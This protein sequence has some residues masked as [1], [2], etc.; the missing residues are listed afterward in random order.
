[1][2]NDV[3]FDPE[4][5]TYRTRHDSQTQ[6]SVSTTVALAL[7]EI[8]DGGVESGVLYDAVDPDALDSLF[9]PRTAGRSFEHGRVSFPIANHRVI[10]HANGTI[11]IE[12]LD[13]ANP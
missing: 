10:V 11:E 9:R 3:E 12:P 7:E 8:C 4:T 1:M 2:K 13:D 5:N 6:Q